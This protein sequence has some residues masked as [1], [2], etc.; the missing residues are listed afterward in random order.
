VDV[1]VQITGI[2]PK[3]VDWNTMREVASSLGIMV[4]VDWHAIF[5][6]FFSLVRVKIQCKD[7]TNIP[8]RRLF[9]F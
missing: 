1:W 5:D 9:V 8:S 3:W 7:P 2:P 6:S 4:E